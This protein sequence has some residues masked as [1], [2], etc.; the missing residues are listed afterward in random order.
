MGEALYEQ[1]VGA[2]RAERRRAASMRRS[3]ATR[4]C[5]PIWC[6]GCWRTAPTPPS[7]T[8]SSTRARRS[9]RSIADP[10]ARAARAAESS[11]IRA[12]RCR[13][14]CSGRSA[15]NSPGHR[16]RPIPTR[17]RRCADG[18]GAARRRRLAAPRRS[19]AAR[20]RR[21]HERGAPIRPTGAAS[22]ARVV[23]AGTA[24]ASTRRS[25]RARAR[26]SRP[27]TRRRPTRAPHASSA[28]PI[29]C[30]AEPRR[31]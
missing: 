20:E 26:R 16:P 13:A 21:G 18:D 30:E 24:D 8:A 1:V 29:C 11:R 15:R 2:E 4:I 28:P 19:S 3:A 6:G 27:G 31:R 14:I 23:E 5:C 9:R 10:V 17:W 12:S 25:T 7:S 22:S